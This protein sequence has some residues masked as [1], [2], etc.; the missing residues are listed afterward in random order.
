MMGTINCF[1]L[2][3]DEGGASSS[4]HR[5]EPEHVLLPVVLAAHA[6]HGGHEVGAEGASGV[7]GAAV[8]GHQ[9]QVRHHHR[10]GDGEHAQR[11]SSFHGVVNRGEHVEDK[12]GCAEGFGDEHLASVE[13]RGI[14]RVGS[15]SPA[16]LVGV[17]KNHK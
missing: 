16:A 2:T 4:E 14:P 11:T 5:A 13:D 17:A 3:V 8:D 12:D 10:H 15:K 1:V 6:V 7:D 9:E